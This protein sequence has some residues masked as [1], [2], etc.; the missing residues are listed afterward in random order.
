[1]CKL[2]YVFTYISVRGSEREIGEPSSKQVRLRYV[3]LRTI[4]LEKVMNTYLL[5]PAMDYVAG[6]TG[7]SC[8]EVIISEKEEIYN[9]KPV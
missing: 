9:S 2:H 3:H 1:M 5:F 6:L 4:T 8:F 7:L